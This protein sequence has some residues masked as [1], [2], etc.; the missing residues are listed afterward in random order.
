[1]SGTPRPWAARLRHSD[2][3][4]PAITT[5]CPSRL[6][7]PERVIEIIL[8][9][10]VER[11]VQG[12][13]RLPHTV[14]DE[15]AESN[16]IPNLVHVRV[17][18][19]HLHGLGPQAKIRHRADGTQRGILLERHHQ[20]FQR[21]RPQKLRVVVEN[22]QMSRCLRHALVHGVG[23]PQVLVVV[24]CDHA[25][26]IGGCQGRG[27][28]AGPVDGAVVHQDQPDR[29]VDESLNR[30]HAAL[31]EIELVPT[32]D[33]HADLRDEHVGIQSRTGTIACFRHDDATSWGSVRATGMTDGFRFQDTS[34][35]VPG[36]G[37]ESPWDTHVVRLVRE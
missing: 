29:Q 35:I 8:A 2:G 21:V 3:R 19:V 18:L 37:S 32:R 27:I 31:G 5:E 6:G 20:T 11:L 28:L 23:K 14:F 15:Q 34:A 1:M 9:G 12:S 13:D 36:P 30:L 25:L 26:W 16:Q 4:R 33:D 22:Q 7:K 17:R 24:K 10:V